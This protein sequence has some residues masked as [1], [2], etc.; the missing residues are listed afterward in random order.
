MSP[1]TLY[2]GRAICRDGGDLFPLD[3]ILLN[4][5][6]NAGAINCVLSAFRC[7]QAF[8]DARAYVDFELSPQNEWERRGAP[9]RIG[10]DEGGVSGALDVNGLWGVD[11]DEVENGGR[12]VDGMSCWSDRSRCGSGGLEGKA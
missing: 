2:D 10:P 8:V 4:V 9:G 11:M 5:L 12:G 7:A 6:S 1:G 3:P